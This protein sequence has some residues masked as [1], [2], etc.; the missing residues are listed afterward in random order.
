MAVVSHLRVFSLGQKGVLQT[1]IDIKVGVGPVQRVGPVCTPSPRS[2]G[3][4]DEGSWTSEFPFR[5][6]IR[7][8]RILPTGPY[9]EP[10]PEYGSRYISG[11]YLA[12]TTL[13]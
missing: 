5:G 10:T 4:T 3:Q 6:E 1:A 7:V 13:T 8:R 9:K 2:H 12:I 11:Q